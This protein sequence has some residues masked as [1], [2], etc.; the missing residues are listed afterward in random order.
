M[1][2]NPGPRFVPPPASNEPYGF[3]P[4]A[5]PSQ[6]SG[7]S[8]QQDWAPRYGAPAPQS[9]PE[10]YGYSAVSPQPYGQPVAAYPGS[11]GLPGYGFL[12]A[13][14]AKKQPRLGM[15]G[16]VLS[17]L[18]SVALCIVAFTWGSLLG[19]LSPDGDLSDQQLALIVPGL[20]LS[21]LVVFAGWV[22]GI[23][24]TSINRGR[25][26]GIATIALGV[27]APFIALGVMILAVIATS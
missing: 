17:A 2:Q 25:A 15:V 26:W 4:Q 13:G 18:G 20:M 9:W 24:A 11:S 22:V 6:P 10:P 12:P 3:P 23:V 16:L 5:V 7:V 1:S 8:V 27:L 19:P 21:G 14:P